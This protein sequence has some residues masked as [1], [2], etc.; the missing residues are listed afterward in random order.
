[1]RRKNGRPKNAI[2]LS[3]CRCGHNLGKDCR[4]SRSPLRSTIARKGDWVSLSCGVVPVFSADPQDKRWREKSFEGKPTAG[5]CPDLWACVFV[6]SKTALAGNSRLGTP[7]F[8]EFPIE[9]YRAKTSAF[10]VVATPLIR[11][12]CFWFARDFSPENERDSA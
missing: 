6:W 5:A 12:H 1:M 4:T 9:K 2:A 11:M 8:L 7:R 3:A 10:E